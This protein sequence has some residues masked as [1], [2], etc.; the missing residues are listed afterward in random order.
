MNAKKYTSSGAA[1]SKAHHDFECTACGWVGCLRVN[2]KTC[3]KCKK[4]TLE[5][6]WN[7]TPEVNLAGYGWPDKDRRGGVDGE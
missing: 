4:K 1:L 7:K 2:R 6:Y 5:I 3:P